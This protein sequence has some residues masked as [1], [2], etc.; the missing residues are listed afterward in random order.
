MSTFNQIDDTKVRQHPKQI[1]LIIIC[2][3]LTFVC[4]RLLSFEN[5]FVSL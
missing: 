3:R 4:N 5:V 2:I 1:R